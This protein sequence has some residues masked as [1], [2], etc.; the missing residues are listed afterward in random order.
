MESRGEADLGDG[1]VEHLALLLSDR[2]LEL[3]GL[4]GAIGGLETFCQSG[5]KRPMVIKSLR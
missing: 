1:L 2:E 3:S 4:A 5:N